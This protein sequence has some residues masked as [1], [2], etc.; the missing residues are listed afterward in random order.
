[1]LVIPS[2]CVSLAPW[3]GSPVPSPFPFPLELSWWVGIACRVYGLLYYY[4]WK[5]SLVTIALA[6]VIPLLISTLYNYRM[7]TVTVVV[8]CSTLLVSTLVA[9]ASQY[10]PTL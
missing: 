3:P 1:M 6:S 5:Q 9:F 7:C 8:V 2:V 10:A 4:T